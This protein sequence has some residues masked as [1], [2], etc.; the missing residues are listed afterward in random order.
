MR[1]MEVEV[2]NGSVAEENATPASSSSLSRPRRSEL[3]I[4]P[5]KII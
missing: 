1:P 3:V 5:M 2:S 4:K